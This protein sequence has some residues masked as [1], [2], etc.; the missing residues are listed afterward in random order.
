M[1]TFTPTPPLK[2]TTTLTVQ[3]ARTTRTAQEVAA[4]AALVDALPLVNP[5]PS[6]VPLNRLVVTIVG[7]PFH[8]LVTPEDGAIRA[9]GFA[10]EADPDAASLLERMAKLDPTLAARGVDDSVTSTGTV[11]DALRAYAEGDV[12]AIDSLTVAQPESPFRG[13]VWRALREVRPGHP[14]TYT[15]LAA[16][17]GRPAAV[18]AAASGCANNL[19]ALV[20][21]CHRIVRSDGGLG[22][23]LFGSDIKQRLLEHE[24]RR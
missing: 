6:S 12:S 21:P 20:V 11:V 10:T 7:A 8:A 5:A 24:R 1:S 22:G 14:V 15:V 9:G 17:A 18:R 16:L 13:E 23:Y 2:R 3:T 19:V 4:K